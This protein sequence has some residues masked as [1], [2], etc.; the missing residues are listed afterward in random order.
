MRWLLPRAF[1]AARRAASAASR[2]RSREPLDGVATDPETVRPAL[3]ARSVIGAI[4]IALVLGL[5]FAAAIM[6]S[7]HAKTKDD[8][9]PATS[10]GGSPAQGATTAAGPCT[11]SGVP[12]TVSLYYAPISDATQFKVTVPGNQPYPVIQQ[13][14]DHVLLQINTQDTAWADRSV[15]TFSGNCENVPV[16]QTP[17]GAYPT[18]CSLT[19]PTETLLYNDPTFTTAIGTVPSGSHAVTAFTGGSYYLWLDDTYAGWVSGAG[20]T[21]SGSCSNLPAKPGPPA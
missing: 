7:N 2:N 10:E 12:A 5:T 9:P 4:L 11:F 18:V 20:S 8:T 14:G 3:L 13:H 6:I 1:S 21:I 16:D 19:S 17:I 15:G